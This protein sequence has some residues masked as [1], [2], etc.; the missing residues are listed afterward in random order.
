MGINTEKETEY[1][2]WFKIQ[3]RWLFDVWHPL[4]RWYNK[5]WYNLLRI[6]LLRMYPWLKEGSTVCICGNSFDQSFCKHGNIGEVTGGVCENFLLTKVRLRVGCTT[7]FHPWELSPLG[8]WH[9]DIKNIN[10][11]VN[12][13]KILREE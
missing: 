3:V 1:P 11:K 4:C 8:T 10:D 9:K 13:R 6:P 12:Y 7:E 5:K 2:I